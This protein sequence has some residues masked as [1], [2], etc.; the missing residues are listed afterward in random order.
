MA[1]LSRA[2]GTGCSD[3]IAAS[4]PMLGGA[5]ERALPAGHLVEDDAQREDVGRAD[6]RLAGRACSGAM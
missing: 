3:R 5:D 6:L 4:T 1:G 2:S